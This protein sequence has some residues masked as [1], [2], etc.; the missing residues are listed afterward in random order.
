MASIKG[1]SVKKVVDFKGHE[2]EPLKQCDVYFKN[3]KIGWFSN[4]FHGGCDIFDYERGVGI[5]IQQEIEKRG[6]KY[7]EE[8]DLSKDYVFNEY[9][10]KKGKTQKDYASE[11]GC[12]NLFINEL[13][14]LQQD[15]KEFKKMEKKSVNRVLVYFNKK[16]EGGVEYRAYVAKERIASFISEPNF[17]VTKRYDNLYQFDI[18]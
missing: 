6:K 13:L 11:L 12:I 17:V 14:D 3:K 4:D 2:Q 7:F 9:Y 18:K 10:K 5:D 16:N 1:I 15:E 8:I